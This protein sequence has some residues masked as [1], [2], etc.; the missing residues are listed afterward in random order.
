MHKPVLLKEAIEYLNLKEGDIA[1][2]ATVDGGGHAEKI[3][4]KIGAS[5]KLIG[6]DQDSSMIEKL[7]LGE[8]A[9]LI[10]GN[11]RD[12]D[13]LVS[14]S[15]ADKVDAILFDLGI[16][17]LQLE[18][19]GRGFSF[20]KDEPLLMTLKQ[21]LQPGDLTA[22]EIINNWSEKEIA[23][24]IFKYGEERYSRRIARGIAEK[25]GAS[26][27][28]TTGELI[29]II[30]LNVPR[31]Y[32]N[33][34]TINCATRTFQAIRIAVNDELGAL[35]RGLETGWKILKNNGRMVVISFHSLEDRIVKN[36][37]KN[38]NS[39]GE[40]KILTKKPITPSWEEKKINPRSRSAKLRAIEKNDKTV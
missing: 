27:I 35:E 11:F 31:N 21:N 32:R 30:R 23:D 15:S 2:D 10:N 18:D 8:N 28:L 38:K 29:E 13:K 7:D 40:G 19:S 16:S 20:Q 36:F 25:R 37:Y 22:Q 4:E 6:I 14:A 34:R 33:S 12:L 24:L 3:L 39:T 9:I 17:S 26:P 1:I 5:G